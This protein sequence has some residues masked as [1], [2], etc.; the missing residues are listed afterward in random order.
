MIVRHF[1]PHELEGVRSPLG[2]APRLLPIN[3]T[4]LPRLNLL[5]PVFRI[6]VLAFACAVAGAGGH[7]AADPLKK[8][9]F[10]LDWYPDAERGG[11]ICALVNGYY[12]DAGLDVEIIPANPGLSPLTAV[13]TGSIDF[14]MTQSDQTMIARSQGLPVVNIMATM[15][16]DP[17]AVMVHDESPVKTFADLDGH[18]VAVQPGTSWFLYIT[19]K[20]NLTHVREARL[21][22]G[23]ANFLIDPNYIQQIFVTSEPYACQ[24]RGVKIRTLLIKDTGCDPYRS[25]YTTEKKISA[26]PAA[27]QAFVTAS[28]KG[29]KTYLGDPASTDA[30]IKRRNPQITQ[31]LIDFSRKT[32]IDGHFVAG[33]EEKGEAIGKLDPARFA[34]QYKILRGVN[35]LPN[36]FDYTK[37]FTTQFIAPAS[38]QPAP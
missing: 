32:L 18:A 16:H 30:E 22:F 8:I 34:A 27:V 23:V 24:Q 1:A 28:I 26:D 3:V 15:Q 9:R 2:V 35:V 7:A 21:T 33:D 10:Q 17:Q 5:H 19:K 37:C 38:G 20:Y 4:C 11:Y 29:W 36:D 14:C 12:K 31:G 13:L 25:V 6:V